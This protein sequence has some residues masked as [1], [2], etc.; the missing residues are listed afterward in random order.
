M[1]LEELLTQRAS[2]ILKRWLDFIF[3]TYPED[4]QRFLRKQKDSFA[5]PVGSTLSRELETL[6]LEFLG[7]ADPDRMASALEGIVRI[8]AIQGFAASEAVAFIFF[9][10]RIIREE[11]DKELREGRLATEE[12]LA[13]ESRLDDLAMQAFDVYMACKEKVFEIRAREAQNHVSGLLRRAGLTVEIPE[14]GSDP[15]KSPLT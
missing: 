2:R 9:L 7:K 6:C 11:T 10:K 8:R 15:Q 14:W 5:N 4:A 1:K 12:L 3:D 13:L